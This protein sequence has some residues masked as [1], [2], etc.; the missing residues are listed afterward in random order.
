MANVVTMIRPRRWGNG[1]R[2]V[3]RIDR[4]I[5]RF[6]LKM[7]RQAF[8]KVSLCGPGRQFKVGADAPAD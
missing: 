3:D 2:S 8:S 6:S 7:A 4:I 1:R 5:S